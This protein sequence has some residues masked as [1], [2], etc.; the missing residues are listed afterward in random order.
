MF[1]WLSVSSDTLCPVPADDARTRIARRIRM[2]RPDDETGWRWS[3]TRVP[4]AVPWSR[5]FLFG[6]TRR[7]LLWSLCYVERSWSCAFLDVMIPN[8]TWWSSLKSVL[9]GKIMIVQLFGCCDSKASFGNQIW[10]SP[11]VSWIEVIMDLISPVVSWVEVI[12]AMIRL[13]WLITSINFG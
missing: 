5:N 7:R 13:L 1:C 3:S 4:E 12:M 9:R 6:N 8:Y 2:V 11:V 10:I